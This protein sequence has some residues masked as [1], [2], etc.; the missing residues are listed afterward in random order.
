MLFSLINQIH[1]SLIVYFLSVFYGDYLILSY[2][3]TMLICR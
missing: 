2:A 1:G 3:R